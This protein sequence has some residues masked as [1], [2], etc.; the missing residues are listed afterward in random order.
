M[1]LIGPWDVSSFE[2]SSIKN[3]VLPFLINH[4]IVNSLPHHAS[5]FLCLK[6]CQ[7]ER[8]SLGGLRSFFRAERGQDP[9]RK[10]FLARVLYHFFRCLYILIADDMGGCYLMIGRHIWD[11]CFTD[12][13]VEIE[14]WISWFGG[15]ATRN[16][17]TSNTNDLCS[18]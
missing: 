5:S 8:N 12:L 7:G 3:V 2:P 4:P 17:N 11:V 1:H 16:R 10:N 9:E 18:V 15:Y 13:P 6:M 14:W